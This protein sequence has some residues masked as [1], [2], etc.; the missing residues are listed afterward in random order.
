VVAIGGS[1]A[2]AFPARLGPLFRIL[3]PY[4]FHFRAVNTHILTPEPLTGELATDR[5]MILTALKQGNAFIGYDLP[6]S[7]RGF[8]F[9]AQGKDDTVWMGDET[10]ASGGITLQIRLPQKAE[11]RL[12][13]DG[14]VIKTWRNRLTCTHIT[15]EPGVFRIEAYI[16]YLGKKRGWIFSNPIYVR[17]S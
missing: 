6:G 14:E 3:F 9:T 5:R 13:K 17:P 12:I 16:N 7:T 11:C 10:S 4:E 1:D 15:T 2:H 8:R